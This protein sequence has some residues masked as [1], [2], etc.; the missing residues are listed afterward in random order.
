MRQPHEPQEKELEMSG[1]IRNKALKKKE[2]IIVQRS[3]DGEPLTIVR[4]LSTATLTSPLRSWFV[5]LLLLLFSTLKPNDV[6]TVSLGHAKIPFFY[7]SFLPIFSHLPRVF[8]LLRF[9][10][11]LS[12]LL[13]Y[14]AQN[15]AGATLPFLH[16]NGS[17]LHVRLLNIKIS[18]SRYLKPNASMTIQEIRTEK[19]NFIIIWHIKSGLQY[20][21]SFAISFK[22]FRPCSGCNLL[23]QTDRINATLQSTAN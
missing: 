9:Y 5:P 11:L 13:P 7:Y 22:H 20:F 17:Q 10:P 3:W 1:S 19:Y 12:Y 16:T 8:Y 6:S 21:C 23:F 15:P 18:R 14:Y 2:E 4:F